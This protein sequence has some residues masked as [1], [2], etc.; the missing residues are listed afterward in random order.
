M[1]MMKK[2]KN[3]VDNCSKIVYM[4]SNKGGIEDEYL[5]ELISEP[6]CLGK[7]KNGTPKHTRGFS[8]TKCDS[9]IKFRD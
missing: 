4:W 7:N 6:Y 8:S 2:I 1:L 9:F 5:K 3:M